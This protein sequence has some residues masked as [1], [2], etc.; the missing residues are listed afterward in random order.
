MRT[1]ALILALSSLLTATL[2]QSTAVPGYPP[3]TPSIP[4][5][6]TPSFGTHY[7]V[8]NL[9]LIDVLV[10]SIN[11]TAQGESF[12][13]S[14]S[15]W[16]KAVAALPSPPLTIFTRVYFLPG[17]PELTSQTPFFGAGGALENQTSTSPITEIYP[18]F[19]TTGATVLQKTR[20]YAGAGNALEEIL[21]TQGIDTVVISGI[22]TSGVVLSTTYRLFDLNYK[23]FVISNNTIESPPDTPGIDA[24]ILE[25][26]IPKLPAGVITLEQ[27]M[28][29][30][31]AS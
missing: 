25:G 10:G 20:Y 29:A 5:N 27:A 26:V 30:I 22:R 17:H 4:T 9:D 24:A 13:S 31:G 19:D 1:L 16:T 6:T 8:L 3:I 14:V 28:A 23:V 7:A 11:T 2:S 18:S 21:S 15:T 12:I